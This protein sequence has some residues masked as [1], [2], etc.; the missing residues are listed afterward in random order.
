DRAT[1]EGDE[2]ASDPET[3]V[4]DEHTATHAKKGESEDQTEQAANPRK[5]AF[6]A[7]DVVQ[8]KVKAAKI[9]PKVRVVPPESAR[10]RD[11]AE[12][13][14]DSKAAKVSP[15]KERRL[16]APP[17]YAGEPTPG[18]GGDS[19]ASRPGVLCVVGDE[20][21]HHEDEVLELPYDEQQAET[22][23]EHDHQLTGD[24]E[25]EQGFQSSE[26][27]SELLYYPVGPGGE[28][29]QLAESD[30]QAIDDLAKRME[31][32]RLMTMGVLKPISKQEAQELGLRTLST[33]FVTTWRPKQRDQVPKFMRRARF[34][35]REFHWDDPHR[36]QLFAPATSSLVIRLLPALFQHKKAEGL[37]WVMIALDIS[38]AYLTV[39]QQIP[40]CVNA[41]I[42][43]EEWTFQLDKLLPGQRDGARE[44]H[45][46]FTS[47][48]K[49]KVGVEGCTVCPSVLR[50]A[51]GFNGLLH[52][53]D[54]LG[55]GT[56]EFIMER[57]VP[58]VESRYKV[59][60][61]LITKPGQELWFLKR[62]L[63]YHRSL[64][65]IIQPHQK[66][67][68]KLF[69]L[70][71]INP[72][73]VN[74]RAAPMPSGGAQA[75]L[76]DNP[77]EE[78]AASKYR[79][80]VGLLLYTSTDLVDCQYCI[81]T[82]AQCMVLWM[83]Q[84]V[85]QGFFQ[86]GTVPT[87]TNVADLNTKALSRDRVKILSFLVG[88]V[89]GE[90]EGETDEWVPVGFGEYE[91]LMMKENT[92]LAI[93]RI[94]S[95]LSGHEAFEGASSTSITQTAKRVFAAGMISILLQPGGSER[96]EHDALSSDNEPNGLN[97]QHD[98]IMDAIF[99]C[100]IAWMA[101]C[102]SYGC[103]YLMKCGYG[104]I[105]AWFGTAKVKEENIVFITEFGKHY[106][107]RNCKWLVKSILIEI[108]E[109]TAV[110]RHYK[111]C[112]TCHY[113]DRAE[114]GGKSSTRQGATAAKRKTKDG[115]V[116]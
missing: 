14:R 96:I 51:E 11:P 33:K 70:M 60:Y 46:A 27:D 54:M 111:K 24:V 9:E 18:E 56:E 89:S 30:L 40:T 115:G 22:M 17:M 71:N 73:R 81:K 103:F 31:V 20:E 107:R 7:T 82:L 5:S 64:R 15:R 58:A 88:I 48:L 3:V 6:K 8:P 32:D 100:S 77:L 36:Q 65:F 63:I 74:P 10:V 76:A 38:D 50:A 55:I 1:G 19:S 61:E 110:A 84:R 13:E 90:F 53:D 44:W 45:G 49:E 116:R 87:A 79:A 68:T 92:R 4:P 80:A 37:D 66:N 112:H 114:F 97:N 106:H 83:Q 72:D 113:L 57:L 108:E 101:V 86:V 99:F 2:A 29:P 78:P 34:V 43:G 26:G 52:V 91:A 94:R 93:R 21:L 25:A 12:E 39:D 35:A 41:W 59:T 23:I 69:E 62:K 95:D 85:A 47:F 105:S 28:E 67:F 104:K 102:I 75:K 16:N 98:W 42:D 109:N